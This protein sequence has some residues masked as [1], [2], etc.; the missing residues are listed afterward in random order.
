MLF[1]LWFRLRF[2]SGFH[3]LVI[4]IL[5]RRLSGRIRHAFALTR[6]T[7]NLLLAFPLILRRRRIITNLA[8]GG[9]PHAQ[10]GACSL[11]DFGGL[12]HLLIVENFLE[13]RFAVDFRRRSGRLDQRGLH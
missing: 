3:G 12:L 1:E 9:N 5:T 10:R 8:H 6:K 2:P 7:K 11:A 4:P 13:L